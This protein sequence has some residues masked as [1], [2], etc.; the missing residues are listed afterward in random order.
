M[1]SQ[2]T[3]KDG[4]LASWSGAAYGCATFVVGT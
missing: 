3:R 1:L 2:K 4:A